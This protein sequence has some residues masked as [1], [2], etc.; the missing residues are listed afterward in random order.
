MIVV[1][2][3]AASPLTNNGMITHMDSRLLWWGCAP[4]P[5]PYARGVL[6]GKRQDSIECVGQTTESVPMPI[7]VFTL[8]EWRFLGGL[9][10]NMLVFLSL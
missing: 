1:M 7:L 10:Y 9:V 6:K 5:E 4:S 8:T 2:R 3:F